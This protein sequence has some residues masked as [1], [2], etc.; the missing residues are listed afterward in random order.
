M[1]AQAGAGRNPCPV[2]FLLMI[3][4]SILLFGKLKSTG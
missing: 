1:R 3:L 2:G 4:T